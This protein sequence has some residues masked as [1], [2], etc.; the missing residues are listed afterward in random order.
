[1]MEKFQRLKGL[2]AATFT[3]MYQDGSINYSEIQKYAQLIV[4]SRINAVFICVTTGEFSS[5][6]VD[7]REKILETC[8]EYQFFE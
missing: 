7:E 8:S 1:M 5:L 6:T 4:N 3:P 2:V